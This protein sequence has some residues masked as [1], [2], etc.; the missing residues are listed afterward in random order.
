[1]KE[2]LEQLYEQSFNL[3]QTIDNL[4]HLIH[5]EDS[6]EHLDWLDNLN[7]LSVSY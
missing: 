6:Q 1:M 7:D 3:C 2:Y 4:T 5:L